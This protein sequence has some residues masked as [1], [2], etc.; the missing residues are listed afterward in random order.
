MTD[1]YPSKFLN[2]SPFA[3]PVVSACFSS[4]E[5]AGLAVRSLGNS[6]TQQD[7]ITIA[8]V[9]SV[10]PQSCSK[11]PGRRGTRVDV[12]SKTAANQELIYEVNMYPDHAIHQRNF[13]A[14]AQVVM[15]GAGE[16]TTSAELA[17]RMPYV[18]C[19]NILDF[20]IRKDNPDWLQ[21]AKYVYTK[22][23]IAVAMPQ[24][25]SYDI[26]LPK[27]RLAPPD[28][29]SDLYCWVYSLE[30]ARKTGK[31]IKEVVDMTVEIREFADRDIGF[32]Q[33]CD[34]Y[35]FVAADPDTRN[36]FLKWQLEL[37]RQQGIRDAAL[38]EG[39]LAGEKRERTKWQ[40]IVADKDAEWQGIVT[41]KDAAL[42]A[43]LADKDG[44]LAEIARLR[45]LLG[46][47]KQ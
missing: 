19:I 15:E 39:A 32:R 22:E 6:V 12:R 43:A 11:T 8:E 5:T 1:D 3:D 4:V 27:F 28:F 47:N 40:G 36:E 9:I 41:G 26:E 29:T 24:Y 7:G 42:A 34:R 2:F 14:A 25:I 37:M 38:E 20:N 30:E 23:P 35:Q 13:L 10:T 45:K 33:F 17:K 44:A 21:P 18:I 46:K 16:G 31:T